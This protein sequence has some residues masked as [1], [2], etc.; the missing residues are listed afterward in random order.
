[1]SAA[2]AAA[3]WAERGFGEALGQNEPRLEARA[4]G[5]PA[6]RPATGQGPGVS[7]ALQLG[8]I[9][10]AQQAWQG[11]AQ[12]A[13]G[14]SAGCPW[15]GL[16]VAG[17]PASGRAHGGFQCSPIGVSRS[18]AIGGPWMPTAAGGQGPD[19]LMVNVTGGGRPYWS[20]SK[21]SATGC[22]RPKGPVSIA[23][24][25]RRGP[26]GAWSRGCS[27]RFL[28]KKRYSAP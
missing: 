20:S 7:A 27:C 13:L 12:D 24:A 6:R 1:M 8:P 10:S 15:S 18:F 9:E 16:E 25:A 22:R 21:S 17:P 5:R 23:H 3:F 11:A 19:S 28:F 26:P 2:F 14:A 4:C